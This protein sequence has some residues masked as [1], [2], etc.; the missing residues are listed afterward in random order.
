MSKIV[1]SHEADADAQFGMAVRAR[2]AQLGITLDQLA[3]ASGV[4]SGALSRVERGL[5]SASLRNALAIARGLGCDIGD[6]MRE[7]AGPQVVRADEHQSILHEDSGI[8]RIALGRPAPG[9]SVLQYELP[10][11]SES[12]HFAAHR[13]GTREMFYILKGTVRIHAGLE[14]VVLR[15]GDT[16]VLPME[17]E[18]RFA[19]E[20]AGHARLIL[21]VSTPQA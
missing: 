14:S 10:P 8:E 20:G 16:A 1:P 7:P 13:S 12:S 21:I 2:R 4:S 6:L 9:L 19:N 18:H 11:G 5:L 3:V 17:T 15:A